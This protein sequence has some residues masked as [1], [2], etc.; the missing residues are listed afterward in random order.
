MH[1]EANYKTSHEKT[2]NK[3]LEI[4]ELRMMENN[5]MIMCSLYVY[6]VAASEVYRSK[7]GWIAQKKSSQKLLRDFEFRKMP[8][9]ICVNGKLFVISLPFVSFHIIFEQFI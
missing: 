1:F 4:T 2:S 8:L 9:A 5:E 3:M 7:F 6:I